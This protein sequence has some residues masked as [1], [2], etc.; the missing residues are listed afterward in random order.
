MNKILK[1]NRTTLCAA[2]LLGCVAGG[3]SSAPKED[4]IAFTDRALA[5]TDAIKMDAPGSSGENEAIN[6]FE[7]FNGDFSAANITNNTKKV[8][9]SGIYFRDPFKE[10]QGETNFE[11]YL[12]RGSAAV[13]QYSIK[14]KDVAASKGDVYFRWVMSVKL[15]RDGKAQPPSLT[16]G[17]SQVRFGPDGKVIFQQDYYDAGAFLYEKIPI[18][19]GEIR[20]IKNRL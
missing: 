7:T 9:S 16:I 3:C 4:P 10:I 13:A 8:Y 17:I 6:R 11:A 2:I 19:G 20:F 5:A 14:W 18:L 1:G 15:K 12:L